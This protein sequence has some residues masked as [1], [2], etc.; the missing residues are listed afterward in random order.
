[1]SAGREADPRLAINVCADRQASQL[2]MEIYQPLPGWLK[3][4]RYCFGA[5]L[6]GDWKA[7]G[8]GQ[9]SRQGRRHINPPS[10]FSSWR[11]RY[12]F[13]RRKWSAAP[14]RASQHVRVRWAGESGPELPVRGNG[15]AG[16]F[17]LVDEC[18][19]RRVED[20]AR[21]SKISGRYARVARKWVLRML[22]ALL[23][24]VVTTASP[25]HD[26]RDA[27]LPACFAEG[28]NPLGTLDAGTMAALGT[29][30]NNAPGL[31]ETLVFRVKNACSWTG[32]SPFMQSSATTSTGVSGG[33]GH[34]TDGPQ[35][36]HHSVATSQTLEGG[37]IPALP[38]LPDSS[39][40][41]IAPSVSGMQAMVS[42]QAAAPATL[43]D[44]GIRLIPT[45]PV[46]SKTRIDGI[47]DGRRELALEGL[48]PETPSGA[49]IGYDHIV[50]RFAA[51]GIGQLSGD[52]GADQGGSTGSQG[53]PAGEEAPAGTQ[54][55]QV[56]DLGTSGSITLKQEDGTWMSDDGP[57]EDGFSTTAANGSS[58][59]LR[60]RYGHWSAEFVPE[61]RPI[62]GTGLVAAWLEDRSGYRVGTTAHL[63]KEG[64]GE[65]SVDGAMYRVWEEDGS[66]WGARFDAPPHGSEPTDGHY[67]I[68][69]RD[70]HI[71]T[72]M[73]D[74]KETVANEQGTRVRVGGGDFSVDELLGDGSAASVGDRIVPDVLADILE[75]RNSAHALLVS[76]GDDPG[77]RG[78]LESELDRLWEKVLTNIKR[79]FQG[80]VREWKP[81]ID[82][83]R[84]I[85]R[86]EDIVEQFDAVVSALSSLEAFQAATSEDGEGIFRE[87]K[88]GE[89][90]AANVF[91]A[92]LS[93]SEAILAATGDTRHGAVR[94][95]VRRQR[96]AEGE[97]AL[98]GPGAGAGVFAYSTIPDTE[99]TSRISLSGYSTYRGRTTAVDGEGRFYT[100]NVQLE[101]RFS[102]DTV[103][104]L[105][106]GLSDERGGPWVYQW[107]EVDA[108]FLPEAKLKF[109]ADWVARQSRSNST[110]IKYYDK[111]LNLRSV[112][113]SSFEGHL[114]GT[115]KEAGHQAV[116]SWSVGVQRDGR[117]YIAGAFGAVVVQDPQ[118]DGQASPSILETAT[119]KATVLPVGADI[120]DGV[121]TLT[122]TLY[123]P[124]PETT[125]TP[126]DWDDEMLLLDEGRKIT[127]VYELPLEEAL[128]RN[129]AERSYLG[130]NLIDLA[131]A[132]ITDLRQD[133]AAVVGLGDDGAAL[134]GERSRIWSEVNE[135]VQAR[136][137]GTGDRAV[138]GR[139][140]ANDE[141]VP[142]ADPRKWSSGYPTAPDGS[143]EDSAALGAIDAVL[144]ALRTP[145]ALAEAVAKNEGGVFTRRD[146]SP[147]R[148]LAPRQIHEI[149]GRADGRI[150]LWTEATDYTRF[151][152]WKKQTA[153]N[154]WSGYR[155]RAEYDENGPNA[156]AY[157]PLPA[158]NYNDYRF[159]VGGTSKYSGSTV[160]V[161]GQSFYTGR[162]HLLVRWHEPQRGQYDAGTLTAVISGLETEQADSLRYV[163]PEAGDGAGQ[164]VGKVYFQGIR[165]GIDRQFRLYFSDPL[166]DV[167]GIELEGVA[168]PSVNLSSDP[169]VTASMIGKFVGRTPEGEGPQAV[170][171]TWT[172]RS[173]GSRRIGTGD[174]IHGG[175]GVE[176]D[177]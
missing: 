148:P 113:Q 85:E 78:F 50:P 13:P 19:P 55:V 109:D 134:L 67:S 5:R 82:A 29:A 144:A 65:V 51:G 131:F 164:S 129:G 15:S 136:I 26:E 175:F 59:T 28:G 120:Q 127:D 102:N 158:A 140:F 90:G 64:R 12:A 166:P 39:L 1:M 56:V 22:T 61:E 157:S 42:R 105:I 45:D 58:Y 76:L 161:Q 139:D 71:A 31:E 121:L 142:A 63:S 44:H 110:L 162:V 177:P 154:A 36:G 52:S 54:S 116:G 66:L 21:D 173:S 112:S 17:G 97:F 106:T 87:A 168:A 115:G 119:P 101:V 151:G 84:A 62:I 91:N 16:P 53:V 117:E 159:P 145:R 100:G 126:A 48:R 133:L 60:Y 32:P 146:G 83:R 77:S 156:F 27:F 118:E 88:K 24:A 114:V 23:C 95:E 172:I 75:L 108:I 6:K 103:R 137:F 130:R 160:A 147:F 30:P 150:Q 135:S 174:T 40:G 167:V 132:E 86:E 143:P 33:R 89:T 107:G 4:A 92:R 74:D 10:S 43:P 38:G 7:G 73:E 3:L 176:V 69:I 68:G 152:A 57:V 80:A 171:G 35:I 163:G 49:R 122:G 46:R 93:R 149:W 153:P 14:Q 79:I 70:E 18:K 2:G 25:V 169:S 11:S 128:A 165:I 104:G 20:R 37:R 99:L 125:L 8:D 111:F 34:T 170:I 9:E 96:R 138:S 141:A 94:T 72:L 124:N 81:L 123:G 41:R 47:G 98:R 155:D